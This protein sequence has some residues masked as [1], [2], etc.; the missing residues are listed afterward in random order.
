MRGK[1]KI[2]NWKTKLKRNIKFTKESKAKK[3]LKSREWGT[4]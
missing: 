4:N 3:K 1:T 2:L